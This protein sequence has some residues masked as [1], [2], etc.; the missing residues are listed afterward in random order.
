MKPLRER[1]KVIVIFAASLQQARYSTKH[2]QTSSQPLP[3]WVF[4]A[5]DSPDAVEGADRFVFGPEAL[6]FR[7]DLSSVWPALSIVAWTGEPG[8]AAFKVAPL[9]IPP[10]RVLVLNEAGDFFPGTAIEILRHARR[11]TTDFCSSVFGGIAAWVAGAVPRMHRWAVPRIAG[12][13]S[14]IWSLAWRT[15]ERIRDAFCLLWSMIWRAGERLGDALNWIW[16]AFLALL[17]FSAAWT[18]PLAQSAANGRQRSR[19]LPPDQP[20]SE[21]FVEIV[22]PSRGWPRRKIMRTLKRSDAE[23][24]VLRWRYE[25]SGPGEIQSLI[26]TAAR[27]GAFAVARQMAWSAWH[28]QIVTRHPFRRLQCGEASEVF[29]PF[30]S[31]LVLRRITVKSLG[32]PHALTY[33]GALTMLFWKASAAGM[34]SIALG[35]EGRVTDEPAM[36]LEDAILTVRLLLSPSLA[37][38]GSLRPSRFRGN[39]AWSLEHRRNFR[40]KPRVLVVSPYLPFPLSHGGAV[41]IWNLCQT[42]ADRVDFVLACFR[43]SNETVDYEH[44]HEVFREVYIVDQDQ[45][46]GDPSVPIQVAEYRNSAMSDLIRSLCLSRRVDVVQLEYTQLAGYRDDTGAVPVILVEHD[47]TFTLYRQLS[48]RSG[49][50]E[51]LREYQRW[52]DFEREALQ[53]SNM[54]WTMSE[55]DRAVALG[56]GA[57]RDRTAVI[58]NGVDLRRY[59]PCPAPAGPPVILFV[60]SLRHL[61]NLLA[62]EALRE[63]VMPAVWRE[64]PEAVLHVIAGPDHERAAAV[65]R[66]KHLLQPDPRIRV[67]GFVPDV[68]C[69]YAGATVV[70]IPLPV[71]AGTNIKV[72]EAMACGRAVVSTP[73]G[74]RGLDLESGREVIIASLENFA[75]ALNELLRKPGL[76]AALAAEARRTAERRFGWDTIARDAMR[77][78][79]ALIDTTAAM[80][81]HV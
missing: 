57:T 58:P 72:M 64:F 29:A 14:W 79:T 10:F 77:S 50:P 19:I 53:C 22:I 9:F 56:F 12:L 62:F 75:V 42:L 74:C 1:N 25:T 34:R 27:T 44:L 81:A 71:S 54:V 73:V 21:S 26:R 40:G 48:D 7:K 11:R 30:S 32:L 23:Y 52:L 17:A 15:G 55:E 61:P 60:G 43:E 8:P 69:A 16:E 31:L 65:A 24:L 3:I 33:G 80:S 68:R 76:Q 67:E 5:E 28:R 2:A 78:Y 36:A 37:A 20:S 63:S 70:A 4:C 39:I 38:L 66:K 13:G 18:S 49:T 47:I 51:S 35:H 41:R 45:V 6:R 59:S 46:H